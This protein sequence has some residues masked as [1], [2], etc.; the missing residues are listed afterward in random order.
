MCKVTTTSGG[1][2]LEDGLLVKHTPSSLHQAPGPGS[3][4][5][6]KYAQGAPVLR[7]CSSLWEK[8]RMGNR[9]EEAAEWHCTCLS[10]GFSPDTAS[11]NLKGVN[12]QVTTQMSALFTTENHTR[13]LKS[14]KCQQKKIKCPKGSINSNYF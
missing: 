5:C 14:E 12:I 4:S 9:G 13:F 7:Y 6:S 10:P 11:K 2:G 8:L 3:H 1:L